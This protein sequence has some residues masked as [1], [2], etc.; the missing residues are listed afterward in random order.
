MEYIHRTIKVNRICK[1]C[2]NGVKMGL[3]Y[4]N[5]QILIIVFFS[6]N[7]AN[8]LTCLLYKSIDSTA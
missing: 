1:N 7:Q 5:E 6:G 4:Y 3:I 8:Q 2:F